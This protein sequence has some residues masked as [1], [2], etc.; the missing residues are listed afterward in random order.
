[1]QIP[2]YNMSG[3][4]VKQIDVSDDVL[5][6]P[7]NGAVCIRLLSAWRMPDRNGMYQNVEK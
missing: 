2:V 7:F 5:P 4:V 6:S 1:M 3:E